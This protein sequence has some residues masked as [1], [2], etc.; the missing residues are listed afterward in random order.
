MKK[1]AQN[2]TILKNIFLSLFFGICF[3]GFSKNAFAQNVLGLSAVPPRLE[4]NIEPGEHITK[5]IKVTN[6]SDTERVINTK[7]VDFIVVDQKGTPIEIDKEEIDN[8][9]SASQWVQTSDPYFKLKPQ[10][11]KAFT[12]TIIVPKNAL[13]GGHYAMALH[14]PSNEVV[15]SETG[16]SI[17]ANVG[18]LIYI[19]VAGEIKQQASV[20]YM[21]RPAFSEYGPIDI[22]TSI[23]NLSDIHIKPIGSI[24]I[25]NCLGGKTAV[26]NYNES[27]NN[28]FPSTSHTFKNTL[29]KK[30]LFGRYQASLNATYGTNGIPLTAHVYF[31]V[32]PYKL[33]ILI[34]V[35]IILTILIIKL[36]H[37]KNNKQNKRIIDELEEE[38]DKLK[39]KYK[40]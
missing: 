20:D 5:E 4:I 21:N 11:T 19:T 7:I 32:I 29:S 14:N 1:T 17:E 30:W 34:T 18:T 2:Q 33:I 13:P 24:E 37:K 3:L 23:S 16:S 22:E 40:D 31:W 28:I 15:L 39:N 12:L 6:N 27:N 9:W 25:K 10:E 36:S 26:L 38:L 35:I 8:R